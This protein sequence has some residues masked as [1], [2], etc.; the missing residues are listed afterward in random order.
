M[1]IVKG[2]NKSYG[3]QIILNDV[4]FSIFQKDKIALIG[5]NGSGKTTLLK[6]L[7]KKE[8]ADSGILDAFG[9]KIGYLSQEFDGSSEQSISDY[10]SDHL[11]EFNEDKGRKI[12][13]GFGL[14]GI[15]KNCPI[16]ILSGGQKSK[17]MLACLLLD[18]PDILLLD[19][20]TNNLDI[21]AIIWLE[22]FLCDTDIPCLVVSHDLKFLDGFSSKVF[23]ID[24]VDKK[25]RS[26]TGSCFEYLKYRKDQLLKQ[27]QAFYKQQ[28]KIKQMKNAIRKKKEWAKKGSKQI[29]T[30]NDKYTRGYS[31]NRS[32]K[33]AGQAKNLERIVDRLSKIDVP[34]VKKSTTISLSAD[35]KLK[36][37]IT[38]DK[39]VFGYDG[40]SIGP[41]DLS[42]E[43]GSRIGLIG[44]NGLGK[45]T[46]IKGIAG[47]LALKSGSIKIGSALVIGSLM[48]EHENLPKIIRVM[49]FFLSRV[50][51]GK[52][53]IYNALSKFNF[54]PDVTNRTIADLSPGE[55]VRMILA[56][57]TLMKVNTILL[58]EPTNHLDFEG[59]AVLEDVLVNYL[60]T[61]IFISHDRYFLEKINPDRLL[62]IRNGRLEQI[63]DYRQYIEY[64]EIK[65]KKTMKS[66]RALK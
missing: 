48:Q 45:S 40:F 57:F 51:S 35:N 56:L 41:I 14:D 49:D 28:E 17:L 9:M 20:P 16:S 54:S 42:I 44:E 50:S 52:N 33:M 29:M 36:Q 22:N 21:P 4:S 1:L 43:Y 25:I 64:C 62:I 60:G 58:D 26:F 12:F 31:R 53:E 6:I 65:A 8:E 47:F 59:I 27:R 15:Q 5:P 46:L 61:I 63:I 23:E 18:G 37:Q 10:L 66:L 2:I 11:G 13:K 24:W 3:N 7:A 32:S 34:K 30:D 38:L 39:A 55:R 19:E